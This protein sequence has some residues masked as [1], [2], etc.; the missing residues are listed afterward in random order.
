M[1]GVVSG[2]AAAITAWQEYGGA[3]RKI[4]RYTNAIASIQNHLL[5]WDSLSPTQG[6]RTLLMATSI[7]R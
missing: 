6:H 7:M 5:W 4:N 1:A 3:D 2:V